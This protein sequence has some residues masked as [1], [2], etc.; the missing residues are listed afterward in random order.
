MTEPKG[1]GIMGASRS[2]EPSISAAERFFSMKGSFL[3]GGWQGPMVKDCASEG[4][5][6]F[7][8]RSLVHY[9]S[10]ER[11]VAELYRQWAQQHCPQSETWL[12]QICILI[13]FINSIPTTELWYSPDWKEFVWYCRRKQSPPEKFNHLDPETRSVGLIKGHICTKIAQQ[14]ARIRK[15]NVQMTINDDF[16]LRNPVT[17]SKGTQWVFTIPS[18]IDRLGTEIHSRIHI[19]VTAAPKGDGTE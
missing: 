14:V 5:G 9:W 11:E 15:E 2:E 18:A 4:R 3:A 6:D 19:D 1:V 16:V 8:Y 7:N 13:A 17:G 10:P 12:V